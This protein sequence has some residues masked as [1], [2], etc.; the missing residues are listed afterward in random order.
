MDA[1]RFGRVLGFGA[2]QAAKT[3]IG[4]VDAARAEN[5]SGPTPA[6]RH[7]STDVANDA[8]SPAAVIVTSPAATPGPQR[9][10][11]DLASHANRT[12]RSSART[13]GGG[14]TAARGMKEGFT[15]FRDSTVEP[16]V[17]LSGVVWLEVTGVFFGIF[18]L[19]TGIAV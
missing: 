8:R 16:V 7:A 9:R 14:A 13:V 15:R 6:S 18:A 10:A 3:V 4:A 1:V 19:S 17:R 2:R 11:A 12:T 5:P